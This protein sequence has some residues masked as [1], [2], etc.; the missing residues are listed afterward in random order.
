MNIEHKN[1]K[2]CLFI[3]IEAYMVRKGTQHFPFR[4]A[5]QFF[6]KGIGMQNYVLRK[7]GKERRLRAKFPV[8]SF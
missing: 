4:K 3:G 8:I 1:R 6:W 5:V 7:G 2:L